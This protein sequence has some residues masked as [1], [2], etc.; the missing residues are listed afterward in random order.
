MSTQHCTHQIRADI[1]KDFSLLTILIGPMIVVYF[2][3]ILGIFSKA[4]EI[5]AYILWYLII[6]A[7]ILQDRTKLEMTN[8]KIIIHRRFFDPVTLDVQN[9]KDTKT[10]NISFLLRSIVYL[11]IIGV[12]GYYCYDTFQSIQRYQIMH[13]PV[14]ATIHLAISKIT[15]TVFFYV[16][17]LSRAERR[18]KHSTYVEVKTN[19]GNFAFYP[20]KPEEFEKIITN[21]VNAINQVTS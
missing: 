1:P 20:D 8:S 17:L 3:L 16:A 13:A 12:I 6:A 11:C 14:E 9:I 7:L 15:L 19:N 18:V 2:F 5:L 10:K 4:F 21:Q